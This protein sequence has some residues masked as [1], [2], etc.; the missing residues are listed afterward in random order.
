MAKVLFVS[1]IEI[2]PPLSGGQLRSSNLI[3]GLKNNHQINVYSLTGRKK[4]YLKNQ[5]SGESIILDNLAEYTN[6]NPLW[7]LIQFFFYQLKLPPIWLTIIL[8]F[9]IPKKLRQLINESEIIILDFPFLYPLLNTKFDGKKII[10]THNAEFK[11]YSNKI[12]SKIVNIIET[13][14][15]KLAD[16]I[17]Y[18]SEHDQYHFE[19][20]NLKEKSIIVPNGIN[21][22]EYTSINQQIN[23]KIANELELTTDSNV[24]IFTGSKYGPNVKAVEKL[25]NF[26]DKNQDFLE[27]NKII[28]LIVGSVGNTKEYNKVVKTT[29][30]VESIIPYLQL[31]NFA[32]NNIE[33]GS[34]TNVKMF[35][36]L[37]TNLIILSTV[38]GTRGFNLEEN[39]DY[40]KIEENY[41]EAFKQAII[42][43]KSKRSEMISSAFLKNK[44][45]LSMDN[46][47]KELL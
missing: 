11:L 29:G 31:A 39:I 41:F 9:Y 36:Y 30:K 28:I 23:Q 37:A 15:F 1:G 44:N 14:A 8:S 34:G 47:L 25:K 4:D 10:N 24:F 46:H 5:P 40:I 16:Q 7:G 32:I 17:L 26:A 27:K 38:F 2:F 13:K 22:K 45:L 33:T 18:C 6:R 42:L 19:K 20:N 12:V 43:N 21:L 35:E 3:L